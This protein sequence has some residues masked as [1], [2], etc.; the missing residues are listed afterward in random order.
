MFHLMFFFL[1][2]SPSVEG[3]EHQLCVLWD[4]NHTFHLP[5]SV[6]EEDEED[7]EDE[8]ESH[9]SSPLINKLPQV[10]DPR[11]H[12]THRHPVPA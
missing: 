12:V 3:T 1:L 6:T 11:G 7:E 5:L 9:S 8:D 2:F 10:R 4:Q